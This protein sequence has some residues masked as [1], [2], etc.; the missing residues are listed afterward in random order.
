MIRLA[1]NLG[2]ASPRRAAGLATGQGTD[3]RLSDLWALFGNGTH[4]ADSAVARDLF[5]FGVSEDSRDVRFA[6]Y[7]ALCQE[8]TPTV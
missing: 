3:M 1:L 7:S 6:T 8:Q 4:Q 2:P 5:I